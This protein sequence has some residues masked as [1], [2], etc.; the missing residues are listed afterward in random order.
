MWTGYFCVVFVLIS[1]SA[2]FVYRIWWWFSA[3]G[4]D[5]LVR[6]CCTDRSNFQQFFFIN[7]ACRN[8][9]L[10]QTAVV[11]VSL[12]VWRNDGRDQVLYMVVLM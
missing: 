10:P 8:E 4:R 1:V 9:R 3:A 5:V 6:R 2:K 12:E 11:E 7:V